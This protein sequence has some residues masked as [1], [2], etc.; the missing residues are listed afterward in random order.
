M[1]PDFLYVLYA[2][3]S[4]PGER[5]KLVAGEKKRF[6]AINVAGAQEDLWNC[7]TK[8]MANTEAR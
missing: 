5:K 1:R 3:Q 6:D 2:V 8:I 4:S 7:Y